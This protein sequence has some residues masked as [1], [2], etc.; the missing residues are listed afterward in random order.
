MI[1][2]KPITHG[3]S[4]LAKA[5]DQFLSETHL[6]IHQWQAKQIKKKL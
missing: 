4:G 6:P 3:K 2:V 5:F 1:H